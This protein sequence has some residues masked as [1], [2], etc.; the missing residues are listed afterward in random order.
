[1]LDMNNITVHVELSMAWLVVAWSLECLICLS[2][3]ASAITKAAS[4]PGRPAW[5]EF[6]DKGVAWKKLY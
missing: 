2:C 3:G 4:F 6:Q 1:M 5:D